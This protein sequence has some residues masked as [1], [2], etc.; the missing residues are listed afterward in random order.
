MQERR[1]HWRGVVEQAAQSTLPIRRFCQAQRVDEQQ[2]YY[3]RRILA[4]E[5]GAATVAS[6]A[7][8]FVLVRPEAGPAPD[9]A[10]AALELVLDLGWRLRIPRGVDETT[11]RSVL[12]VLAPQ[13]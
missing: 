10:S 9:S 11:L 5:E 7:S 2:Y 4:Q 1:A 8:R 3:W 6:P 12:T 13:A